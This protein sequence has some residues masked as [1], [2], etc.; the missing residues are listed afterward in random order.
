VALALF[1]TGIALFSTR[2]ISRGS[3]NAD[4]ATIKDTI[5]MGFGQALALIPG[6]S[7]SGSTISTGL[8]RGFT[9]AEAARYSFLLGIPAIAGAGVFE[10][11]DL[12]DTGSGIGAEILVGVVVAAISG[13][14]AIA[15]LL[16]LIGRTGLSPFG[17][18]CMVAAT[19]AL[20][21]L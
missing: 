13:Y 15:F 9:D 17:L 8:L 4:E 1:L 7:R 6:V 3:R 14:A 2:W 19:V 5:I 20:L 11:K 18:Y 16:R 21:V 12:L 10:G